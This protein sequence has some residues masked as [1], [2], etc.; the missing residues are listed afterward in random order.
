MRHSYICLLLE[1]QCVYSIY[2]YG[3]FLES[4]MPCS[5][6][7]NFE[8]GINKREHNLCKYLVLLH[9]IKSVWNSLFM[10]SILPVLVIGHAYYW[11]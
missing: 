2:T 7:C 9:E 5:Y 3:L 11:L 10:S 6:K 1:K 4:I 8:W